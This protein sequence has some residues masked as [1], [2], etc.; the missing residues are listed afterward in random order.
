[1]S[2]QSIIE[3]RLFEEPDEHWQRDDEWSFPK[4]VSIGWP[5]FS[6][7]TPEDFRD[8]SIRYFQASCSLC[9]IVNDNKVED[10]VASFPIIFLFRHSVELALKAAVLH[11]TGSHKG[12]HDLSKLM[13]EVTGLPDWAATWI[14]ELHCLDERSTGL[15]FPD[16]DVGFFEAGSLMPDW[17]EKTERLHSVLLALSQGHIKKKVIL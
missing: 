7:P 12:G 17:L 3:K 16:T 1:M 6:E 14:T 2:V 10:Y 13:K 11:L 8:F 4:S 5:I 9:E 15:R